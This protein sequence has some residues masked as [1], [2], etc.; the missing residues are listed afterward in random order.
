MALLAW[1]LSA[2]FDREKLALLVLCMLVGYVAIANLSWR[3][4]YPPR[5]SSTAWSW[6][7]KWVEQ[8][9]R[10]LY[11]VG[12]PCA[13]LARWCAIGPRWDSAAYRLSTATAEGNCGALFAEAGIPTTWIVSGGVLWYQRVLDELLNVQDIGMA[14]AI[15]IG[16]ACL[17][18]AMWVWYARRWTQPPR[19][20]QPV[21]AGGVVGQPITWWQA[22]REGLFLQVLWAFYRGAISMHIADSPWW[23]LTARGDSTIYVAFLVLALVS[24]SW[25]LNPLRRE[26]AGD[27]S[28]S[29]QVVRDWILILLTT[30]TVMYVRPLWLLVLM[31]WMWLWTSDRILKA[32]APGRWDSTAAVELDRAVE[33]NRHGPP[34]SATVY[35]KKA[36]LGDGT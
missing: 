24:V 23:N 30:C 11:Y 19:W 20:T 7:G 4:S 34:P 22:L 27:P 10:L 33:L 32:A 26:T 28:R 21:S 16:G 25:L 9:G 36:T 14:A 6:V 35:R 29:Y 5:L 31:H 12:V 13:V 15:W 18:V 3:L 17:F 1:L 2:S 8:A